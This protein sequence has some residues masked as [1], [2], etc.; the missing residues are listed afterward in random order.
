M[1]TGQKFAQARRGI[2]VFGGTAWA[3][4][5]RRYFFRLKRISE[6]GIFLGVP[7]CDDFKS[8]FRIEKKRENKRNHM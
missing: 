8:L 1:K 5:S 4:V 7:I 6:Q 3:S 2:H